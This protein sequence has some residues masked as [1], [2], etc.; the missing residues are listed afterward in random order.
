MSRSA[1]QPLIPGTKREAWRFD[2]RTTARVLEPRDQNELVTDEW[3]EERR[4]PENEQGAA[5]AN[6]RHILQ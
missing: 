1:W 6:H 5:E 3:E 4:D 2:G